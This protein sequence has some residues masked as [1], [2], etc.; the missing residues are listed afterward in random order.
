[1]DCMINGKRYDL[2]SGNIN[3]VG[4]KVYCNGRYKKVDKKDGIEY[5]F[6]YVCG[7][8]GQCEPCARLNQVIDKY[9]DSQLLE[10]LRKR[11]EKMNYNI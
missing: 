4:N 6:F 1:M 5:A 11:D 3:I 7:H 2:P 9:I 10:K 8:S